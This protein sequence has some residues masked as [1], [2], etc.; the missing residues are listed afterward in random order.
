MKPV[1]IHLHHGAPAKPAVGTPCNGCGACCAVAPCPVGMLVSMKRRGRC[2]ML[3]WDAEPSRYRCGMLAT[4]DA[5]GMFARWRSRVAARWIAAGIGC[6]AEIEA[7][8][9][10]R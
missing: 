2:V 3:R 4:P 1:V 7:A 8:P 9:P 10:S 6:D 5:R